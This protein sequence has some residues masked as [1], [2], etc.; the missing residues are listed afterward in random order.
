MSETGYKYIVQDENICFGK[1]RIEGTRMAVKF[2]V[3]DHLHWGMSADEICHAH[4][5]I[6]VVQVHAALTYYYDH[7]EEMDRKD[8]EEREFAS[9][10]KAAQDEERRRA[11]KP[12]LG[13]PEPEE[14]PYIVQAKGIC[15]G[16]PRIRR[17][18]MKVEIIAIERFDRGWSVEEIRSVHPNLTK[19][20]ILAA[21][22]YYDA[23]KDEIDN[24]IRQS[25]DY[26]VW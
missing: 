1:P 24:D 18:Q 12:V 14:D 10:M 19:A 6:A 15:D 4:P 23:H 11:G 16:K 21:L 17:S 20:E 9:R 3:S 2:I 26:L 13:S 8:G 5:G 22:A 25:Y 7:K